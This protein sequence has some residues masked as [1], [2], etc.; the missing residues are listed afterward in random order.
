MP[1]AEK[2]MLVKTDR[3]GFQLCMESTGGKEMK[4]LGPW[5]CDKGRYISEGVCCLLLPA[6]FVVI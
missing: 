4:L 5:P 6:M 2:L 1:G 3:V